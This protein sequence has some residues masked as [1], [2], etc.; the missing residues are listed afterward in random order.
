MNDEIANQLGLNGTP[1]R[2]KLQWT[3]GIT[4]VEEA[5][6]TS[7]GISAI[8][9]KKKYTLDNVYSVKDLELPEQTVDP[10]DLKRRYPH[11][12]RA[13]IPA[14][15][16]AKPM[17]LIGLDQASFLLSSKNKQGRDD[18]P[19]AVETRLGWTVFGKASR[20]LAVTSKSEARKPMMRNLHHVAVRDEEHCRDLQTLHRVVKDFFTTENFGVTASAE[21]IRSDEDIRAISVM[22]KT[23]KF[24]GKRYEIGLL[25]RN[26]E[27]KLPNSYEMS[28]SRLK[29]LERKL[30]KDPLMLEWVNQHMNSLIIK[31]YAR[32]ATEDDLSGKWARIWYPPTFV[33]HNV[34]KV[35]PKPRMVTD[36]AAKVDGQSLNSNL[37]SGP[38]NLA[39]LLAGLFKFRENAVAVTADVREM[40]HQVRIRAEDQQCQR[41][42][43]R[44]GDDSREPTVYIMES[45]MFGPTCSPACAQFV[46]N[47]HALQ[48]EKQYPEAVDA[49]INRTY[50]DDYLN[51]EPTVEQA[52]RVLDNATEIC[53]TMGFQLVAVQSNSEGLLRGRPA[54]TL[55]DKLMGT[56]SSDPTSKVLGMIWSSEQDHFAFKLFP[57]VTVAKTASAEYKP[58]KREVLSTL[59]KIYD[60]LGLIAHYL[61]RGRLVLQEVWRD[62]TDWDEAISEEQRK[63]W[64]EF[65]RKLEVIERLEIPRQYAP[66]VPQRSHVDLVVFVDA[67]EKAFAATA[68]FRFECGQATHV[69]HVM[70]KAKVAPIKQL[71]IPQLELQAAVLGVRLANSV[72]K[73]H[74]FEVHRTLFLA[75]AR[76]VLSWIC[77]K[78]G[79]FKPFVAVRIGEILE[80]STRKDWFHISSK[81]NV[82][83]DA[84]KWNENQMGDH[85]TRWFKGPEFL[86]QPQDDWPVTPAEKLVGNDCT[87]TKRTLTHRADQSRVSITGSLKDRFVAR[88]TST[89]RV[90]AFLMRW[91][92]RTSERKK[93]RYVTPT[94]FDRA[95]ACLFREVQQQAYPAEFSA[96]SLEKEIKVGSAILS[97]SPFMGPDGTI[98]MSSRAQKAM[99]S[100]AARNPAILPNKHPLVDLLIRHHHE[101]NLHMG[102]TT[103]IADLRE[104]AWIVNV[105]TAVRRVVKNCL[106]CKIRKAKPVMPQ[107][108]QLP[109]SRFAYGCKPFT[110][111]GVDCF[112]P[113]EVK[114]GRGKQKRYGIIFTCLTYRAVHLELIN[115]MSTDEC[116]SSIRH[117]I[118]HR[119][120]VQKLYSDNGKNFV[121]ANNKLARDVEELAQILGESSTR[122]L[123]IEWVFIPAYSPWMGGAWERM[124]GTVKRAI[125]FM[126]GKDTPHEN[127][128]RNA[129]A[130]AQY[131]MNR[132]PLTHL[133]VFGEDP[134]PLTPNLML[135]GE[136]DDNC[137]PGVF[138]EAD[139]VSSKAYRRVQHLTQKFTA[140]WYKEYLPEITRRSKW[141]KHTPAIEVGCLVMLIEPDERGYI[142]S[143]RGVVVKIYPG[144]DGVVRQADI[145]LSDG[146]VKQRRAAGNLALLDVLSS[147]PEVEFQT[148][149]GMSSSEDLE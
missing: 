53:S 88:W 12:E 44:G 45:M 116:L 109:V 81:D 112:G 111:T 100:Y 64:V 138:T 54:N 137:A 129:L 18:E 108:G 141:H 105:R 25:W 133:P 5:L 136:D 96:L 107:M 130:E 71:S 98:R 113:L 22:E 149:R 128:L 47:H 23:L 79:K 134:K 60:P 17:M 147:P 140:R 4:R 91:R 122:R 39:P 40:F 14:M 15:N 31:G 102:E 97:L 139:A 30:S 24:D 6:L 57:D 11:L 80:A 93:V 99:T 42:L 84:T 26:D 104:R 83:D 67:S 1:K 94:E 103:T 33:V 49:L 106:L 21:D 92:D 13:P 69:A 63:E 34:N 61:I 2:L 38:D 51:S 89:V 146:R 56:G 35:P 77:S 52:N 135:F 58:T 114:F 120:K 76:V 87:E 62:G 125:D 73:H 48:Y 50:V 55:K 36:V 95:E 37:L 10:V 59:M 68:Y 121:G 16:G 82:A 72:K 144:P 8:K 126:I 132:R 142:S 70:A 43:W 65:A 117:L 123:N 90:V 110:H 86:S 46:K 74:A 145:R 148:A 143:R 20:A 124:I 3:A 19:N 41:L 118:T 27:V 28:L 101:A 78:K 9:G 127:V 29:S 66:V 7:V 131:Q 85:D 32:L 115:D 119:G 75:D